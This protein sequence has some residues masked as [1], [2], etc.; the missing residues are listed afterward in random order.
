MGFCYLSWRKSF[1]FNIEENKRRVFFLLTQNNNKSEKNTERER[2]RERERIKWVDCG[3]RQPRV[4]AQYG[5][6]SLILSIILL[7]KERSKRKK[8]FTLL[9]IHVFASTV[10]SFF[11]FGGVLFWSFLPFSLANNTERFLVLCWEM[12]LQ[13]TVCAP[14]LCDH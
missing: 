14:S 9:S 13:K 11:F 3:T 4:A 6:R 5:I 1:Q 12:P 7:T 2:E 8:S 10:L